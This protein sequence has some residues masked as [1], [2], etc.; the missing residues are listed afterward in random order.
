VVALVFFQIFITLWALPVPQVH[1][2]GTVACGIPRGHRHGPPEIHEVRI[3]L[4]AD[5]KY[6]HEHMNDKARHERK[7]KNRGKCGAFVERTEIG[8]LYLSDMF[9]AK[10]GRNRRI[11]H[12]IAEKVTELVNLTPDY[13]GRT[14]PVVFDADSEVP[15][16]HVMGVLNA[17]REI[18]VENLQF[19][20]N[21]RFGEFYGS[22]E[23]SQFRMDE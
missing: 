22:G 20:G 9:P 11:Y 5:P 4:C 2:E 12:L 21:P 1:S 3:F 7:K 14:P 18:G 13:W 16:E 19:V 6:I 17:C 8:T 15:Y 23:K 10:Q